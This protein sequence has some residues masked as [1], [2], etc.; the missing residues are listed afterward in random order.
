[1][2]RLRHPLLALDLIHEHVA[3]DLVVV[4]SPLR[5]AR[6][7]RAADDTGGPRLIF[8]EALRT[9]DPDSTSAWI[10]NRAGL[11]ALM[12]SAGFEVLAEPDPEVLV[13]RPCGEARRE[14]SR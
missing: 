6:E 11:R 1:L 13:C 5:A 4:Q 2:H 8:V 3:R 10:P 7:A 9:G 14:P 12:R